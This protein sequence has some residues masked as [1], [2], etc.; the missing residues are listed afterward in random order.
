MLGPIVGGA[1]GGVALLGIIVVVVVIIC[2]C[3]KKA[4]PPTTAAAETVKPQMVA[5]DSI[6]MGKPVA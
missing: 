2:C 4:S 6:P 1:I 5:I 3:K